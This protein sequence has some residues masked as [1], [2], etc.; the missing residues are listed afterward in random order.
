MLTTEVSWMGYGEEKGN[1]SIR[2]LVMP[3]CVKNVGR[4]AC[5]NVKRNI[6][7]SGACQGAPYKKKDKKEMSHFE[8]FVTGGNEKAD[9][10]AKKCSERKEVYAALQDAA[11]VHCLVEE[12]ERL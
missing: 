9:E 6:G 8:K 11:G 4:M 1:A 3:T 2:K 7:G 12:V 5:V 10:L